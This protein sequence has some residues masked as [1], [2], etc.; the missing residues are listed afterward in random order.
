MTTLASILLEADPSARTWKERLPT[1]QLNMPGQV[2]HPEFIKPT[3]P[4]QID[5]HGGYRAG[6]GLDGEW[7]KSLPPPAMMPPPPDDF[8]YLMKRY[9]AP[10]RHEF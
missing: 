10:Q 5:E 4:T 7:F 8:S 6:G 1:P 2:W 9:Q 3:P